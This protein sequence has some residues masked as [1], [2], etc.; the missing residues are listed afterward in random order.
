MAISTYTELKSAVASWLHDDVFT[1]VIP[2]F[3]TI[4]EASLNRQL[5]LFQMENTA[6]LSTSVSDRFA[7]LPAGFLELIDLAIY[8]D[9]YPQTLTQ[10]SLASINEQPLTVS[11]KP[12]FYAISSNIVFDRTSDQ[13]YSC[14]LRYYKK[15]DIATD[16]TNFLLTAYPDLYLYSALTAAAPYLQDDARIGTWAGLLDNAIRATNRVDARTRGKTMLGME[17]GLRGTNSSN[18]GNIFTG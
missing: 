17:A 8:V 16:T 2:D 1:S 12:D 4:G 14:S 15:L 13:V 11:G 6:T 18:R 9:S 7:T 10:V 5:R 3:I